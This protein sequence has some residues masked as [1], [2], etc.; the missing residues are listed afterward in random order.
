MKRGD[1]ITEL[2]AVLNERTKKLIDVQTHWCN[3]KSVDWDK[4][5]MV[6]TGLVDDLDFFDVNLGV[7]SIYKKPKIKTKCLIGIINNNIADAFL[8]ECD[9]IEEIVFTSGES[10]FIIK[11]EGFIVKQGGE[12]LKEVFNDLFEQKNKLNEE[13]QKIVVSIGVSPNV[14]ALVQIATETDQIKGRLNTILIE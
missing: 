8:I 12:S 3:V 13:V 2:G 11:E 4:K 9:E 5:T 6:A 1:N 10:E 7:G 14:P